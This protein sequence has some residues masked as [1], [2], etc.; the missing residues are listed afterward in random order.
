M[1]KV[2]VSLAPEADGNAMRKTWVSAP[3]RWLFG[4]I[5]SKQIS[6]TA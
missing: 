3:V 2:G 5:S 1:G 6:L 4:E